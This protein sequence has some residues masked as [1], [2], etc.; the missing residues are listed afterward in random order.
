MLYPQKLSSK[1]SDFMI[2]IAILFSVAVGG[3]LVLINHVTTP[4]V[5]WAGLANA[6]ILYVW[7]NVFYAIN[8]NTNIAG[9]VLLETFAIS[10]LTSYID[11][12]T[13][14]RGWAMSFAIPIVLIVANV[15][16]FV[17]TVVSHKKFIRYAVFQPR[18][19]FLTKTSLVS[20][21]HKQ[22]VTKKFTAETPVATKHNT[23]KSTKPFKTK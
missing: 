9:Y 10:F 3:I 12:K 22:I 17:L 11:Y 14:N 13:G 19:N 5:H 15:T 21:A 20:L 1:K 23:P 7:V 18:W 8:H 16:M 4:D 2:V 6:G